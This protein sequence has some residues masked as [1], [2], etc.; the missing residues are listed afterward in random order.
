MPCTV[1]VK[2]ALELSAEINAGHSLALTE[3]TQPG[4]ECRSHA[5]LSAAKG[6]LLGGWREGL[7]KEQGAEQARLA[8]GVLVGFSGDGTAPVNRQNTL[9]GADGRRLAGGGASKLRIR[10][11]HV[12][13]WRAGRLG[14]LL[15]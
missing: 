4:G 2:T 9:S 12:F 3:I 1:S 13:F 10:G 6:T 7:T 14:A 8:D 15:T 11:E 5:F